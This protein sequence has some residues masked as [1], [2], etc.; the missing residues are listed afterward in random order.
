MVVASETNIETFG[1]RLSFAFVGYMG[2]RNLSIAKLTTVH[3]D[4]AAVE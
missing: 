3:V 1:V 4:M 2:S